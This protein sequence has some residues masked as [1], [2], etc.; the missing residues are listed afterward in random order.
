MKRLTSESQVVEGKAGKGAANFKAAGEHCDFL[1]VEFLSEH[2]FHQLG[3]LDREFRWLDHGSI[4]GSENS[5]KWT[6]S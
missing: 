4:A 3:G 6:E 2:I 1:F 5:G